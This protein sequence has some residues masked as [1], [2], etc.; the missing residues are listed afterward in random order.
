MYS[1]SRA[2]VGHTVIFSILLR[3]GNKALS[4]IVLGL[5]RIS[6]LL[7]AGLG[8]IPPQMA[9]CPVF[10]AGRPPSIS[11]LSSL[12]LSMEDAEEL[13][14]LFAG[15][16]PVTMFALTMSWNG[17]SFSEDL[18]CGMSFLIA[19]G[20]LGAVERAPFFLILLIFL[21]MVVVA[22][23]FLVDDHLERVLLLQRRPTSRPKVFQKL[24]W[25]MHPFEAFSGAAAAAEDPCSLIQ[26][27]LTEGRANWSIVV[28]IYDQGIRKYCFAVFQVSHEP[29]ECCCA[30]H[31]AID[32]H[33]KLV[34]FHEDRD[35]V[36]G[37]LS[38][39]R[40]AGKE[41]KMGIMRPLNKVACGIW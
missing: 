9:I 19:G 39:D 6:V 35:N 25:R 5:G 18:L 10:F 3:F 26:H 4:T 28:D 16:S 17:F 13:L 38:V 41:V 23:T 12:D 32:M 8:V 20:S 34:G 29:I 7:R 31:G 1:Q 24:L 15:E 36:G 11:P 37:A 40:R 30:E 2:A 21:R 33:A 27:E 22:S 14:P